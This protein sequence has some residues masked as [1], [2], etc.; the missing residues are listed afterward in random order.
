MR[1]I[2]VTKSVGRKLLL[3]EVSFSIN[4]KERI[5]LIGRNGSGKSTLLKLIHRQDIPTDGDITHS[6]I[7]EHKLNFPV[8]AGAT[9]AQED[10]G[11]SNLWGSVVFLIGPSG[12]VVADDVDDA[13]A[14]LLERLGS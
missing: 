2:D 3:D 5:G 13:R 11:V 14:V 6:Y 7:R 9:S 1:F 8:L 10:F 4:H 12:V